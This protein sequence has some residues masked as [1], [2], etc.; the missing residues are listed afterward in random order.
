MSYDM[1]GGDPSGLVSGVSRFPWRILIASLRIS[2]DGSCEWEYAGILGQHVAQQG[3]EQRHQA[4][5]CVVNLENNIGFTWNM[6]G[7]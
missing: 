6:P 5:S 7:L 2:K 4:A 3:Y 1:H